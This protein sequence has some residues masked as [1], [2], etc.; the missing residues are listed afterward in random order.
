[1]HVPQASARPPLRQPARALSCEMIA[2]PGRP[3]LCDGMGFASVV[4]N[5]DSKLSI[6]KAGC[7]VL[8]LLK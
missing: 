6:A 8:T 1:M 5:G 3:G 4:L 7:L 2:R